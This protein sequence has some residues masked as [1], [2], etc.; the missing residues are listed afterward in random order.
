MTEK[1]KRQY[2]KFQFFLWM[3]SGSEIS[4]L[5]K[6]PTDYNRHAN[7]GLIILIT[8]FFAGAT[9]FIA[10]KTFANGTIEILGFS[11]VW[12]LLILS[13][14]RSMVN[15]IKKDPT[16][17]NGFKWDVF[18][19]R[20]ILA[21]ILAFFMS[22]PLDHFVFKERIDYQMSQNMTNDWKQ[23]K[24]DL[25]EGYNI[26]GD[27]LNYKRFDK[28]SGNLENQI[29]TGCKNCPRDDYKRPKEEADKRSGQLPGLISA[30]QKAERDYNNYF[31]TLR[32]NQTPYG[33]PLIDI[34]DVK[35]DNKLYSLK[36]ARTKAQV[37]YNKITAEISTLVKEA[38]QACTIWQTEIKK[39]K[40]I[41]DSLKENT[42]IKL[43]TNTAKVDSLGTQYK[44]M[45]DNM[46]GFDTK[47]VTLFLMPNW[48]VQV[49]KWLI[50][51]AL[52]VIEIL[53]TF[54]KLKTPIGQYDWEMYAKEKETEIETKARIESL[55]NGVNEIEDYRM[56]NETALN[57]RL[58]DKLV[59]IEEKLANEML[60]DWEQKAREQ[61][62]KD[63][64]NN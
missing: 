14:D 10:G 63:V 11:L 43:D 62:K 47:F 39:Q 31:S 13:L 55:T 29:N 34:N 37:A 42:R 32:K 51:L 56:K 9:A 41:I 45:L 40:E 46:K 17:P 23:R 2:S 25:K 35:P 33:E 4:V 16:A 20:L 8:S 30:K 1:D 49:L 24:S 38:N 48:G 3:I 61:M 21:I 53:P 7:Q 18:W 64:D 57:K 28:E 60:S 52:L 12:S 6:C 26:E 59:V 22:I 50:F 5:K 27:S 19:P 44:E 58:I 36:Q 54:L 15:S